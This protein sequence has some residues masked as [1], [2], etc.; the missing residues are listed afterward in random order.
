M[1]FAVRLLFGVQFAQRYPRIGINEGLLVNASHAARRLATWR[2]GSGN[3]NAAIRQGGEVLRSRA[4]DLVRN[5][6]YASNAAA[7]FSAHAVGCGIKPSSLV[8]DI[9][10]KD[11]IQRLWL[12]WSDEADVDGVTDFYGLQALAARALFEAG[13]CF[14]R[15]RSRRPS[16]GLTVPLQLQLIAAEQLPLSK[17]ETLAN[18]NEIIFGIEFDRI[19]RRVAYHFLRVHP[20]DVRQRDQG[21]T[22]RVQTGFNPRYSQKQRSSR[23]TMTM[24]GTSGSAAIRPNE[25]TRE[26][27]FAA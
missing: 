22:V 25:M 1:R 21:Q 15:L 11:R 8:E 9:E 13:E 19:G 26:G 5:N 4:R 2:A 12:A 18:G 14:F 27:S 7:S 3:I 20:G 23:G 17:C 10:L 24:N 6:P 16:D